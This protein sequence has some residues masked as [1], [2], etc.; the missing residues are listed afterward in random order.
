[1]SISTTTSETRS[2]FCARLVHLALGR[3]LLLLELGDAGGLLDDEAAI[4]GLATTIMP[5]RPCSM[6]E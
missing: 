5:T 3:L 1:L 4:L 6:I 2:R